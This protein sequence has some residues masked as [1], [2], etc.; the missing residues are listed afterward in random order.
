MVG[1]GLVAG[2]GKGGVCE[3]GGECALGS[4]VGVTEGGGGGGGARVLLHSRVQE[5]RLGG[6]IPKPEHRSASKVHMSAEMVLRFAGRGA[7]SNGPTKYMS[8]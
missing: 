7:K 4:G 5:L 1:S 6:L 2:W 8:G 3:S